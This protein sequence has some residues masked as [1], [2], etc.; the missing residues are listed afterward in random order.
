MSWGLWNKIKQGFRKARTFAKNAAR[1]I[2]DRVIKPFKPV[3][4]AVA[5]AI[6]PAFGA[7]VNTGMRAVERFSDDG[8]RN[9]SS[10][11]ISNSSW[12]GKGGALGW[13]ADNFN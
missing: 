8:S 11:T 13:A 2:N 1:F 10:D 9:G 3:I 4:G 6:N 7:A 12:G 5:S